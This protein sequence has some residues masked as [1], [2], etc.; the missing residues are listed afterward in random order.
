MGYTHYWEI[1]QPNRISSYSLAVIRQEVM[2]AYRSGLV[3]KECNDPTAPVI[4][5]SLIRFNG[6]GEAG[7]ET[8]YFD[9]ND[10]YRTEAGKHFAF[11]KT[12]RKPYDQIVMRVLIAL[13]W[14]LKDG[15]QVTSDGGFDDE[16]KAERAYMAKHYDMQTYAGGALTA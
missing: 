10:A 8:F 12:A 15:L 4:T 5:D 9:M 14:D 1:K 11:C 7:H 2:A 13:Q 3:Q 16:W 6:V